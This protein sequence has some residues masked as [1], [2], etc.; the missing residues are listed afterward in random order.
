METLAFYNIVIVKEHSF[1]V[2]DYN[3]ILM[4]FT[5]IYQIC[6]VHTVEQKIQIVLKKQLKKIVLLNIDIVSQG[7]F[8]NLINL[9]KILNVQF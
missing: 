8:S 3:F 7:C 5:D 1:H 9:I 4:N 6:T 2:V